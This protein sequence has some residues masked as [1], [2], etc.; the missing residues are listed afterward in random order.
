[1]V[2]MPGEPKGTGGAVGVDE[3]V[4][5]A[6]GLEVLEVGSVVAAEGRDV[7]EFESFPHG[8]LVRA[9]GGSEGRAYF[10]ERADFRHLLVG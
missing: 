5:P 2:S 8:G 4:F 3:D 7:A 6:G 1:M 9:V 10:R